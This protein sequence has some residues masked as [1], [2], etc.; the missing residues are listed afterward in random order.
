MGCKILKRVNW[1]WPRTFQGRF[2]IGRVGLAMAS[3]CTKFEVSRF[4]RY[5]AM[6]GGAK[7]KLQKMRWFGA[8]RGLSRSSAMSPFDRA[9]TTSYSTLIENVS[10]VYRFRDTAG[11]L[12]KVADSDLLHLHFW[13]PRRG[14]PRLNFVEIF[15]IRKLRVPRL[16]CGVVCGI[17]RLAVL[18]EHG[19]VTDTG[20]WLVPR[21]HSDIAR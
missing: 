7:C 14:W 21:M 13:R 3:Q 9:D 5:E 1:P 2:F 15:G 17:L 11:Y 12:S 8:V 16:S 19:L 4:T 10:I 18:V 20:P 6:N